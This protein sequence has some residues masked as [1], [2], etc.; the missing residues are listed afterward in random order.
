[1][2]RAFGGENM[3]NELGRGSKL[4]SAIRSLHDELKSLVLTCAAEFP[5]D[6]SGGLEFLTDITDFQA[7]VATYH[8][9]LLVRV[10]QSA[11]R[12]AERLSSILTG[13]SNFVSLWEGRRKLSKK[14]RRP[15]QEID[16]AIRR[17]VSL[18]LEEMRLLSE[19]ELM[20]LSRDEDIPEML[21]YLSTVE[22]ALCWYAGRYLARMT[23]ELTKIG[24]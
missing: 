2:I 7:I 13:A 15:E 21:Y 3:T 24:A 12:S 9:Q 1:M 8:K 4:N 18:L 22:A 17:R 14:E 11:S 23:G 20:T 10:F 19:E 6:A 5:K 16:A